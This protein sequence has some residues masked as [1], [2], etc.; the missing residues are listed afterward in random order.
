MREREIEGSGVWKGRETVLIRIR[1][2]SQLMFPVPH[3]AR[4]QL[5]H[6]LRQKDNNGYLSVWY[7]ACAANT[8]EGRIEE[9]RGKGGVKV[10]IRKD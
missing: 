9:I 6:I 7:C 3:T 8:K 1:P 4:D 5:C 2:L 10:G